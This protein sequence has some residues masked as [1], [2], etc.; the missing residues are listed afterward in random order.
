MKETPK[1][2]MIQF[3]KVEEGGTLTHQDLDKILWGVIGKH[4]VKSIGT[5]KK[6]NELIFAEGCPETL[7][8]KILG[9]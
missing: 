1:K 4:P 9:V 3:L 8:N 7:I 6:I 2:V 5:K